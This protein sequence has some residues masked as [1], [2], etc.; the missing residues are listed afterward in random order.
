MLERK[1]ELVKNLA[2]GLLNVLPDHAKI[3]RTFVFN[4]NLSN[5]NAFDNL[6]IS[7][8]FFFHWKG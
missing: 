1:N 3:H 6:E 2:S 8:M 4:S 7:F 5:R